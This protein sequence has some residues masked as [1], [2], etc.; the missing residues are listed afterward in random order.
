M[1]SSSKSAMSA[2]V[3]SSAQEMFKNRKLGA[4]LTAED[5]WEADDNGGLMAMYFAK[6]NYNGSS[7]SEW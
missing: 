2:S 6:I 1:Y 5:P 4:A 7:A 3:S